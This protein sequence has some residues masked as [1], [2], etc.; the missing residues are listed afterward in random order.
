VGEKEFYSVKEKKKELLEK[1][2]GW[3]QI[4]ADKQLEDSG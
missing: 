4:E 2:L 1:L 3:E